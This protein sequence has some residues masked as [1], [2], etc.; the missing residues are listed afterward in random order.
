MST[1]YRVSS[2]A[3][4]QSGAAL[5]V[6]L[7]LLAVV[8]LLG[9]SSM[10]S[11]NADL[12]IAATMRD[13]GIAFE[14]AEAALAILE[15]ELAADPPERSDLLSTCSGSSSCFN[16]VCDNG[17][18]FDGDYKFGY[19]EF[20]CEV[21][22]YASSSERVDFWSDDA[23][24]VWNDADKHKTL[25]I[26]NMDEEVKY[27]IEFLCF[28]A[29]DVDTPFTALTGQNNNGAPLYRVTVI[30]EGNGQRAAV[31]LQSTYKVLNG[32]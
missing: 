2:F 16:D 8:T 22:D 29:R 3:S 27:I 1:Y 19:S 17:L 5:I 15:E 6:S 18:C 12:K 26:Q 23:L 9:I 10:Q 31:A 25:F 32:H 24:D 20:E 13:R 21:A 30:A 28:V 11:S 7:V 4:R 14:A